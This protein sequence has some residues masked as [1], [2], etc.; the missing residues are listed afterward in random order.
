MC[1]SLPE[2]PAAALALCCLG[3]L[4]LGPLARSGP[5]LAQRA[6]LGACPP[7]RLHLLLV[8]PCPPGRS[9]GTGLGRAGEARSDR[10][11]EACGLGRVPLRGNAPGCLQSLPVR[12]IFPAG[13]QVPSELLW[14][15][16]PALDLPDWR[17]KAGLPCNCTGASAGATRL[18][19]VA[20]CE[21]VGGR[22]DEAEG[23][24]RR[25]G[26]GHVPSR[27][28]APTLAGAAH[29]AQGNRVG[30]GCAAG[31]VLWCAAS[32][33]EPRTRLRPGCSPAAS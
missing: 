14:A 4:E 21:R 20:L 26:G 27:P 18:R 6:C 32:K 8:R 7:A 19:C 30:Q 22:C 3:Q 1:V 23:R 15:C 33:P 29:P 28:A 13:I 12:L 2:G 9:G 31:R 5:A 24:I 17:G 16:S 10:V 11:R 25:T